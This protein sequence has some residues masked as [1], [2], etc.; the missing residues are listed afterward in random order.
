[1]QYGPPTQILGLLARLPQCLMSRVMVQK[2]TNQTVGHLAWTK[3]RICNS[4][5]QRQSQVSTGCG[6]SG[7]TLNVRENVNAASIMSLLLTPA[8]ASPASV[9]CPPDRWSKPENTLH[10]RRWRLEL[11]GVAAVLAETYGK[12][13]CRAGFKAETFVLNYT[14][15]CRLRVELMST[16][17]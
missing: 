5:C 9:L 10:W 6:R 14:Q 3:T 15:S 17:K 16:Q 12:G 2:Q 11:I 13:V 4:S 1:M 7:A 8:L